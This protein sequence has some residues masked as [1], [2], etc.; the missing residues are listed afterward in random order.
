MENVPEVIGVGNVSH[1][2]KWLDKLE[3]LGYTNHFKILNAKDYGIPQNRRRCFMISLLGDYAY[4][5]PLKHK[6]KYRLKD[7]LEKNVDEK[8]YLTDEK[9]KRVSLWKAQQKPLENM[10]KNIS[11]SPTLTARGAGEEHS[12]MVLIDTELFEEGEIVDFDS[13]DEFRREHSTEETPALLTHLKLG[14]VE[15]DNAPCITANAMQSINHQNCA[16]IK[17]GNYGNGHHAKDVYD[18]NGNS[19]TITTGNHGLG[20]AIIDTEEK[21]GEGLMIKENN[22]KGFKIAQPGDGVNLANRMKH[23]RGNVQKGSI[24][25]LKTEMEIGVVVEDEKRS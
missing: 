17:V 10:Q 9:I 7:F 11:I 6:L 16:L 14:V 20:Q 15:K 25:T 1:F 12:G 18:T 23:Q 3:S 13:S 21:R 4:D 24:Q 8:Y 5:F 19:P 22:S 2:N